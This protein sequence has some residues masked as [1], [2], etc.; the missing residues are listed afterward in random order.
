MPI[1]LRNAYKQKTGRKEK[2]KEGVSLV[3]RQEAQ[4]IFSAVGPKK[5]NVAKLFFLGE[6]GGRDC[7]LRW[8]FFR[9]RPAPLQHVRRTQ[10]RQ[11]RTKKKTRRC[12]RHWC[13]FQKK[14][15]K[16]EESVWRGRPWKVCSRAPIIVMRID[17]F[18]VYQGWCRKYNLFL[19]YVFFLS[20]FLFEARQT[21]CPPTVV[22]FN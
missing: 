8:L 7:N 16:K 9:R 1:A 2:K 10:S 13:N 21:T 6:G 12:R 15:K 18:N 3:L 20:L 19:Y 14:K 5:K 11:I 17:W 4:L 22:H